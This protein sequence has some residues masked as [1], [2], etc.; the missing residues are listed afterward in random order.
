MK[1]VKL[2]YIIMNA[3]KRYV[4][5]LKKIEFDVKNSK[6]KNEKEIREFLFKEIN[7]KKLKKS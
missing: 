2:R 3:Y 6:F 1:D 5:I 4:Y 7:L